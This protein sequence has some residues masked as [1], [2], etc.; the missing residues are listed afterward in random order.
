VLLHMLPA[1]QNGSIAAP[2]AQAR[3]NGC[4]LLPLH[5]ALAPFAPAGLLDP[6]IGMQ[7][8]GQGEQQRPPSGGGGSGG[9]RTGRAAREG[10]YDSDSDKTG[11]VLEGII[12]TAGHGGSHEA[13]PSGH[14]DRGSG[15]GGPSAGSPR[16]H[17]HTHGHGD[18]DRSAAVVAGEAA[19]GSH[20]HAQQGRELVDWRG[21]TVDRAWSFLH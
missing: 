11:P 10:G 18:S 2:L 7:Q 12:H 19:A 20:K 4:L 6:S 14:A 16:R 13:G 17:G 9:E 5:T 1:R 3:V 8:A 15:G 21:C